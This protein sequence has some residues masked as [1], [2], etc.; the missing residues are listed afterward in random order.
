MADRPLAIVTGASAG[1]GTHLARE[2]AND[3]FDVILVARREDRLSQLANELSGTP[4]VFVADLGTEEGCAGLTAFA[5][6]LGA[7]VEVLVNNAGFGQSGKFV[8]G[9][10]ER[11]VA[12]V[13]LNVRAVVDL[14]HRFLPQML[15][16]GRGGILNVASTAAFQ[17]GPRAATYYASKAFVLSFSEALFQ[18]TR[19]TGVTVTALCP[20]PTKTEFFEIA[21]MD[22]VLL[23]KTF[24]AQK[25]HDV[26]R[27]GW[28][29]FRNGR[30]AVIP[31]LSS[32]VVAGFARILPHRIMLP[33]VERLQS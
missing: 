18:E 17:P 21:Q 13:D 5:A 19:G 31:S 6:T 12:M 7:P 28:R 14:S 26:A 4:R 1:I 20:G 30:R 22:K 9:S 11:D 25:A 15:A 32:R 23:R 10:A 8:K 33:V 29:A 3:G 27:I 24:P 2:A 16:L